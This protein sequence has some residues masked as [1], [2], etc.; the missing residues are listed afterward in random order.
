MGSYRDGF[1]DRL[2]SMRDHL[3][4]KKMMNCRL[5]TDFDKPRRM[6]DEPIESYNL[7]KSEYWVTHADVFFFVFFDGTDNSSVAIE[8][9]TTLSQIPESAWRTILAYQENVPSLVAGLGRR[10]SPEISMIPF[11]N[12]VDLK[13]QAVGNIV[14]LLGRF[15]FTVY[16]RP[17]GEWEYSSVI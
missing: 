6:P 15:Y 11:S 8:L 3:I 7:R 10:Y 14:R 12:D 17:I 13:R 4:Q 9:K 16:N 5:A 2:E 1:K